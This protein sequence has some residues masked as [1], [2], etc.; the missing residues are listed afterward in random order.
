MEPRPERDFKGVWIPREIWLS[1]TLS[2][3]EKVL[4]VEVHSLDNERGCFASNRHFAEFFG[5]SDRQIRRHLA[6]LKKKGFIHIE[7]RGETDRTIR[8]VGRYA[9]ASQESV[10]QVEG[11]KRDLVRKLSVR[12]LSTTRHE[13]ADR[14]VRGGWTS[15]SATPG[16]NRPQNNP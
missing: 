14:N 6:S 13:G 12:G 5:L 15:M 3:M 11:L 9:R 4:F 10:R 7:I 8:V 16:R 2:L 1:E